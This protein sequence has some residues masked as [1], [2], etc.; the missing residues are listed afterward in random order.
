MGLEPYL[1]AAVLRGVIA[2]R[3][4]RRLCLKCSFR[5]APSRAESDFLEAGRLELHE[6]PAAAGCPECMGGYRGRV[7]I[8]EVF[9]FDEESQGLISSGARHRDLCRYFAERGSRFIN[10]VGLVS[11]AKGD[12]TID[13]VERVLYGL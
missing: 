3:L 10:E 7:A 6:V 5:R 9:L 11:V 2:Q 12:T 8:G 1:L 4:V 13:E